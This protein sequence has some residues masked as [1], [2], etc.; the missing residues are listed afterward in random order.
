[1][2][3]NK[4]TGTVDVKVRETKGG[5]KWILRA[6]I[7]L[8]VLIFLGGM[9]WG[10][11]DI[12]NRAK[13]E[14]PVTQPD[15][16][17]LSPPQGNAGVYGYVE[18]ALQ[19]AVREKPK[20]FA[21]TSYSWDMESLKLTGDGASGDDL[22]RLVNTVG[23]IAPEITARLHEWAPVQESEYGEDISSMLWQP[24]LDAAALEESACEFVF[25]CCAV[26]GKESGEPEDI[27]PQCE[28]EDAFYENYR[29]NYTLTMRLADGSADI[30]ANFH[31]PQTDAIR[32]QL[33][34]VLANYAEIE[35]LVCTYRNAQII[36]QVSRESTETQSLRYNAAIDVEARLRLREAFSSAG[37]VTL[38]FTLGKK[39]S[40]GFTWP[41]IALSK[42]ELVLDKRDS[43]QLSAVVSAP[44]GEATPVTW[45][46]SNPEI[47]AVED[48]Y[49]DAG[50]EYG[51]A[52]ITVSFTLD[53]K[54]YSDTCVVQVKIPVEGVK[55]NRKTLTL[56]AGESKQ[57][58]ATVSPRDA[59]YKSIKWHSENPLTATVDENGLV[60]AVAPG[61]AVIYATTQDGR[62]YTGCVTTVEEA[63]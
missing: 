54:T 19:L 57:L 21:D 59:T 60:R 5:Q 42:R 2:A 41:G 52:E 62:Y 31:A 44:L 24:C 43:T 51:E 17:I 30:A 61:T 18:R 27:C 50:S 9:A 36:A 40:F 11:N 16:T 25:Y 32:E 63:E 56:A 37:T 29:T 34:Q 6:A 28:S 49:L 20:L 55:L 10:A 4:N 7:V 53:G 8:L 14:N 26:C 33:A 47:C 38:R 15:D 22:A 46:S 48:G 13:Q 45:Q 35:S 39:T 1:M 3:E 58:K 23:L 12:L